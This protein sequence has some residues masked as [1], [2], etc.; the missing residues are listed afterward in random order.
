MDSPF[1]ALDPITPH[2]L[3]KSLQSQISWCEWA[4]SDVFKL[5][6]FGLIHSRHSLGLHRHMQS[7]VKEKKSLSCV[8]PL[9]WISSP[10]FLQYL[11]RTLYKLPLATLLK[12]EMYWRTLSDGAV[13]SKSTDTAS[14]NMC[15]YCIS[16]LNILRSQGDC[17]P[18]PA[19]KVCGPWARGRAK[20]Y[21]EAIIFLAFAD[22]MR[23]TKWRWPISKTKC[24]SS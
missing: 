3:E 9:I 24:K 13:D 1:T 8:F 18:A 19:G 22:S 10:T 5:Q 6:T 14:V 15:L 12:G 2:P 17:F 21:R 23:S 20:S 16:Q 11:C 7:L 4:N